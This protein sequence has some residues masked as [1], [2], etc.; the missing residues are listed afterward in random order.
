[1]HTRF[2]LYLNHPSHHAYCYH[3]FG[4]DPYLNGEGAYE[5]IVGV[6]RIGVQACAKHFLLNNQEHWQYDIS[7]NLDNC[8]M[9]KIYFYPLLR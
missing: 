7:A 6:E 9:H 3:S 1:M 2:Y 8:T 4:P 5:T